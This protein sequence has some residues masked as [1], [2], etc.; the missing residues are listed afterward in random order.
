[1][2]GTAKKQ[3]VVRAPPVLSVE[4]AAGE[5]LDKITILEIKRERIAAAAKLE[6]VCYELNRLQSAALQAF[7]ARDD[8]AALKAQLRAVNESL[9]TIEDE[10]RI[11]E[12]EQDFSARFIELA[13]SV[14]RQNDRR[15]A[16]KR[17]INELLDSPIVEEKSYAPY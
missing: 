8:I 9:W 16:I 5:L 17:R 15:A 12:R 4:V 7:G 13:R 1:M 14:Y 10:I 6:N 3:K 2:E 11:C